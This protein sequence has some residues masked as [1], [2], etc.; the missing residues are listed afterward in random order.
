MERL[1]ATVEQLQS[2]MGSQRENL[3]RLIHA[4]H[5]ETCMRMKKSEQGMQ[6]SIGIKVDRIEHF[7]NNLVYDVAKI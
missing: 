2:S 1:F 6:G 7:V 5:Q 4:L 3:E